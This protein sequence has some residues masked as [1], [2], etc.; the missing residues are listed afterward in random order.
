M[1]VE[2]R[3]GYITFTSYWPQISLTN[4]SGG[5]AGQLSAIKRKG[6]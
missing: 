1:E 2:N 4:P 3:M 6:K 5:G